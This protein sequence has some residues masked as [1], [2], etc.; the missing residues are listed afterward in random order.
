M[1]SSEVH[2]SIGGEAAAFAPH[3]WVAYNALQGLSV[4]RAERRSRL[5]GGWQSPLA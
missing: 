1:T 4:C 5:Q 2:D 3:D